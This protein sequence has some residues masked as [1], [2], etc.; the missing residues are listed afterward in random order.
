MLIK[1][2]ND[3]ERLD[4]YLTD[5]TEYSRVTITKM[6]KQNLILVNGQVLKASHVLKE[7]DEIEITA[8]LKIENHIIAEEMPLDIVY[9]DKYLM[10]INKPSGLVVHP[11]NG[12]QTKTLV[13]G[14]MAHT[15]L[16]DLN[17]ETRPGIVHRID[18]DTSGLLLVAKTNQVHQLLADDFKHKRIKRTYIALLSGVFPHDSATIDAPIGR[19]KQNRQ[20]MAVTA[21]NSKI[22]VTNLRVVKK[23]ENYTLVELVLETGRTHQIRVHL[24]YIG[25]PIYNDPVYNTKNSNDFGQF[26]HS[27]ALEFTHPITK[28]IMHFDCQLPDPFQKFMDKLDQEQ[29]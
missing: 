9:E 2:K 16:S 10:V 28:E 7:N 6:I 27:A 12:H 3:C 25:Y 26:L 21:D 8:D 14:L 23:Y 20:K 15:S 24:S 19:D 1:V 4:K 11:G 5:N 17:G 22:A 29:L 13:N 18:K